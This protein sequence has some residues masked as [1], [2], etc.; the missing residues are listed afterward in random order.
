M[1]KAFH[2]SELILDA[3]YAS[4]AA[5]L[6]L[7]SILFIPF[8]LVFG[9][10]IVYIITSLIL[11]G[12]NIWSART[13]GPAEIIVFS[14]LQ[15]FSGSVNEALWQMT[16]SAIAMVMSSERALKLYAG[17]GPILRP[18]ERSN[19]WPVS[20]HGHDWGKALRAP[21]TRKEC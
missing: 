15:G 19:K 20:H 5:A 10:R 14:V 21:S 12:C 6:G 1:S 7:G 16:V 8:A 9:R 3:S 13:E 18:S 2:Y 17:N 11:F 4:N